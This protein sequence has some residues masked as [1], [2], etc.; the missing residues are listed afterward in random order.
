MKWEKYY[1]GSVVSESSI[2]TE[3][4]FAEANDGKI[5]AS[6]DYDKCNTQGKGSNIWFHHWNDVS[7]VKIVKMDLWKA[8]TTS[9][10]ILYKNEVYYA[11]SSGMNFFSKFDLS[12]KITKTIDIDL[13]QIDMATDLSLMGDIEEE[14][15]LNNYAAL[16]IHGSP[17]G[18]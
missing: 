6:I 15:T 9:D 18:K 7:H 2:P 5:V 3:C 12:C 1:I 17:E 13:A 4:K 8:E 14:F 16:V 11:A 10:H